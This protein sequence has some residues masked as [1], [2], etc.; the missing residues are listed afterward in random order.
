MISTIRFFVMAV[1]LLGNVVLMG[2]LSPLHPTDSY[3]LTGVPVMVVE[4]A[5][6]LC[7]ARGFVVSVLSGAKGGGW[8]RRITTPLAV[9]VVAAMVPTVTILYANQALDRGPGVE[10]TLPVTRTY[11]HSHRGSTT[12]YAVVPATP[13]QR[14]F[15]S[16]DAQ[17]DI[18][19][20]RDTSQRLVPG[21]S[22]L[23]LTIHPGRFG[24]PW[25][26]VVG[27]RVR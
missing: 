22:T 17:E 24:L 19:L 18:R 4:L 10:R 11:S 5:L 3:V 15:A 7:F 25:F 8:F 26:S 13:P 23:T 21:Q 27:T 16:S 12:Y 1:V 2:S 20:P 9:L 6:T 14:L